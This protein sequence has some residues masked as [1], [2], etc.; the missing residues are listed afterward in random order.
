MNFYTFAIESS[1]DETSASVLNSGTVLSNVISSQFFHKEYGGIVPELASRAHLESIDTIVSSAITE[2][3]INSIRKVL[4]N[5][6]LILLPGRKNIEIKKILIINIKLSTLCIRLFPVI[7][8]AIFIR[9]CANID[10][11]I[12]VVMRL[13]LI[14][15]IST[16]N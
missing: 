2:A 11:I 16:I 9:S 8:N 10:N 15:E 1:C 13:F 3:G 4:K 7:N 12:S 6:L 14:L 5:R